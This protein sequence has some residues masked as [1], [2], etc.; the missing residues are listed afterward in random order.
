M[1][2]RLCA[3]ILFLESVV[4]GLSTITLVQNVDNKAV[5]LSTGLG[6][7]VT[8]LS[9]AGLL[10]FRWAYHLGWLVQ[11]AAIALG[12]LATPMYVLGAIFFL[13][14]LSAFRLGALIE[15]EQAAREKAE[16]A[17]TGDDKAASAS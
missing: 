7:C 8:C 14:W 9:L 17:T 15:R 4:L 12:A 1:Q 10:R 5:A 11:V 3:S 13:L 2:R 16:P 6:L